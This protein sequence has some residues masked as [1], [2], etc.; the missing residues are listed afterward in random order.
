MSRMT[1]R[2]TVPA[3]LAAALVLTGTTLADAAPAQPAGVGPVRAAVDTELDGDITFSRPPGTFHGSISVTVSTDL[4]GAEVRYTTNGTWPTAGS[5]IASGPIQLTRTTEI[6]AQAF[7]AGNPTGDRGSAQYVATNVSTTHDLPVIVLDA[8]GRGA[9]TDDYKDVAVVEIQPTGGTLT[10][11]DDA[12]LTVRGGFRLRGS[13]SRMFDKIPYRIELWDNDDDGTNY[14][15]V[16]MPKDD[17]WVLRGPFSDKSLIREA[18]VMDLAGEMGL[19]TPRYEFVEVYVNTDAQP[20]SSSDYQGVYMLLETIKENKRRL[21]ITKMGSSDVTEPAVTGGYVFSMEWQNADPPVLQCSGS[22]N[23]WRDI[24]LRRPNNPEPAQIQWIS[25]HLS[26][27][28][29]VLDGQRWNDPQVGYPAWIDVDSFVDHMIINELSRDLD[30][31]V[32]STYFYKDRGGRITAGPLWDYD[33]TFGVGGYFGNEQ[34]SGWQYEQVRQRQPAASSW[35]TRLIQD[36]AFENRVKVRWQELRRGVLS[37][38]QLTARVDALAAPLTA[39]AARNFQRYPNNLRSWM[40]GP[41]IT[42]T[43]PTWQGQ[44]NDMRTWMLQRARW[45]DSAHDVSCSYNL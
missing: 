27:F 45:L 33:L 35:Y 41:F 12:E 43:T 24:E 28:Q 7:V 1:A 14:P 37:D 22:S 42:T 36:P 20:V 10:L 44:I 21:D 31:Y 16:G 25:N 3:A 15:L 23:C 11:S 30:A 34:T 2:R 39:A 26:E 9:A 38:A 8:Y 40:V 18:L 17:D 19:A 6:R 5:Q 32:R 13:S 4:P 29:R